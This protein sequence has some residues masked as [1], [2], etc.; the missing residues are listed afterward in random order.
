MTTIPQE[1]VE[2]ILVDFDSVEDKDSLESISLTA[3]NFA[4][5]AQRV[6]FRSLGLDCHKKPG[7]LDRAFAL[8][9]GSPHIASYVKDLAIQL[10]LKTTPEPH[11]LLERLLPQF[12]QVRR[13]VLNGVGISWDYLQ[14]GLQLAL[15]TFLLDTSFE[16]LH[17]IHISDMPGALIRIA[18]QTSA[19]LSLQNVFIKSISPMPEAESRPDQN[20]RL[21]HLM[22]SSP[23]GM[24]SLLCRQLML[25]SCTANIL[26]LE[27]DQSPFSAELL[28][29]IAPTLTELSLN[30]I[31]TDHPFTLPFLP[32]L[33]TLDFQVAPSW[34][35]LLPGWLPAALT[36][37]PDAVPLLHTLTVRITLPVLDA[38]ARRQD[39][40]LPG[41]PGTTAILAAVDAILYGAVSL[42]IWELAMAS[43]KA[44]NAA[45]RRPG[46]SNGTGMEAGTENA[47]CAMV[48]ARFRAAVERNVTRMCADGT[49]EIRQVERMGYVESLP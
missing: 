46:I 17:L 18:A 30:C 2:V 24:Q 35:S 31:G 7:S 48:F 13:F 26:R 1:L 44:A 40:A 14:P 25:P 8:L 20:L 5:P 39:L 43:A 45:N 19:V 49:L 21:T 28:R 42:C 6:L 23:H 34:E 11:H 27:V 29:A 32:H 4:G 41:T 36:S 37:L 38:H 33:V 10:P 16:K 22:L 47:H 15:S 12:S 3:T 9:S